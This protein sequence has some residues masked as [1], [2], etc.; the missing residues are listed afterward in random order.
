VIV[1][2]LVGRYLSFTHGADVNAGSRIIYTVV[3]A[4]ISILPTI[5][6]LVPWRFLFPAFPLDAILFI[7]WLYPDFIVFIQLV[8]SRGR[9]SVWY[10]THRGYYW[11]EFW[12]TIPVGNSSA[13]LVGR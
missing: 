12:H 5:V 10:W 11:R 9:N 8:S 1:A 13:G 6:L 4:G 3:V 7:L 2:N